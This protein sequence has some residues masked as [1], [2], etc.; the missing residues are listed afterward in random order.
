MPR[1]RGRRA[2]DARSGLVAPAH[3]RLHRPAGGG[4]RDALPGRLRGAGHPRGGSG[5][6]G[7]LGHPAR[8][9]AVRRRSPRR[10]VRRAVPESQRRE[11]G[12]H[13]QPAH[14]GGQG[15]AA[16]PDRRLGRRRREL[17]RGRHGSARLLLRR[18]ARPAARHRLRLQ[19]R[20]RPHGALRALQDLGADRAGGVGAHLQF[21][22]AG[23]ALRRLGLLV[24]GP[25]RRLL[26]GD[27]DHDGAAPSQRDRRG[28]VGGPRHR[29]GG[30]DA[31]RPRPA[32]PRRQRPPA[33]PRGDAAQQPRLARPHG[34]ARHLP[35]RRRRRLDRHRLPAR[36]GLGGARRAGRRALGARRR[37]RRAGGPD[38][39]VGRA[40]RS[41]GR[42]D[43][44]PRRDRAGGAA[45]GGGR[46]RHPRTEPPA[47]H[48]GGS[49]HRRLGPL[50]RGAAPAHGRRA[51]RRPPPAPL[52]DRLG[53]RPGARRCSGSTTTWSSATFWASIGR[54]GINSG[55]R[56]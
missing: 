34:A 36:C 41:P 17:L 2:S 44:A 4:R 12:R 27:G 37:A 15:S 42:L 1:R 43:R 7:P 16:P 20:L 10:G 52:R 49:R 30:G 54:N 13:H 22:S 24:Y 3:L 19:L 26:H 23:P 33:A 46:P 21:R 38:R 48:R 5:Q 55:R 8:R 40:R 14:G 47:A 51:R 29:R 25:H 9:A 18:H 6:R 53:D 31:Q 32:R 11:A 45:A 39:G 50:A 35:G 56:G 28:A